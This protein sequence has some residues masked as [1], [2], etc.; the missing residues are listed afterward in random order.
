ML[1]LD[2]LSVI[3]RAPVHCEWS[4][5]A[6]GQLLRIKLKDP[7]QIAKGLR[8]V[9]GMP[10]NDSA[11]S[12]CSLS[13]PIVILAILLSEIPEAAGHF[14][15]CCSRMCAHTETGR[16][17]Y[18]TQKHHSKKTCKNQ[19]RKCNLWWE[20]TWAPWQSPVS[21]II[22]MCVVWKLNSGTSSKL[23]H[24]RSKSH[25][26]ETYIDHCN[27]MSIIVDEHHGPRY[28]HHT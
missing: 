10:L 27:H 22:I 21:A 19:S 14:R 2:P 3:S 23:E 15:L 11:H 26:R 25:C 6:L 5:M 18:G 28:E 12:P 7:G 16:S 9:P 1:L 13:V 8:K 17:G 24:S 4:A 20:H